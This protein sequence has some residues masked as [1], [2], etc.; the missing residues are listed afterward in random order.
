MDFAGLLLGELLEI[1]RTMNRGGVDLLEVVFDPVDA[2]QDLLEADLV[3]DTVPLVERTGQEAHVSPDPPSRLAPGC[4]RPGYLSF[5]FA[6]RR[7][8]AF[9]DFGNLASDWSLEGHRGCGQ[10]CVRRTKERLRPAP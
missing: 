4:W 8:P 10:R 1:V 3:G 9:E 5:A 7:F 2:L 6:T